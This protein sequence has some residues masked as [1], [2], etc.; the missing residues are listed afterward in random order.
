MKKEK[1]PILSDLIILIGL[2][3]LII[4][5]LLRNDAKSASEVLK[6]PVDAAAETTN[7]YAPINDESRLD[8][9]MDQDSGRAM[10]Y[11]IYIPDNATENM[12]LIVY[13][14]GTGA[15]GNPEY[16]ENNPAITQANAVYGDDFPFIL[17]APSS[18]YNRS[19]NV[20]YVP[21]LLKSLVDYIAEHYNVDRNKIILFG[22]SMGAIG[23]FRQIE[24][25]GDFYSAAVPV[26]LTNTDNINVE[27]STVIPIWGFS[28]TEES[29]HEY[30]MRKLFEQINESGGNAVFSAIEG[31]EHGDSA[32]YAFT[33]EV[34]E[35]ALAQ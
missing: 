24:L 25:F 20:K 14:H 30:N 31:A 13:L 12:P 27:S 8:K 26:S 6:D 23:V 28:G 29:P 16:N 2:T 22:H 7:P 4:F 9:F 5:T 19:W 11:H 21:D 33:R 3:V 18:M 34:F 10:D 32:D 1:F 35:W 17:L 15:I